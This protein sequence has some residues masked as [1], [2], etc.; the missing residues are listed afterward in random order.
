MAEEEEEGALAD[1]DLEFQEAGALEGP[2]EEVP[3]QDEPEDDMLEQVEPSDGGDD[4]GDEPPTGGAAAVP[5]AESQPARLAQLP[6]HARRQALEAAIAQAEAYNV[7][8]RRQYV[9]R[10]PQCAAA[11]GQTRATPAPVRFGDDGALAAT[12][13]SATPAAAEPAP[14]PPLEPP[15]AHVLAAAAARR[16]TAAAKAAAAKAAAAKAAAPPPSAASGSGALAGLGAMPPAVPRGPRAGVQPKA[17]PPARPQQP[18]MAPQPAPQPQPA[19][20]Q[21]AQPAAGIQPPQQGGPWA[22]FQGIGAFAAGNVGAYVAGGQ[23]GAG[24]PAPMPPAPAAAKAGP[25]VATPLLQ[26]LNDRK[27]AA[28]HEIL[29]AGN[30]QPSLANPYPPL[31]GYT[32]L[33]IAA[34][35]GPAEPG[36]LA[37]DLESLYRDLCRAALSDNRGAFF[38]MLRF[39]AEVNV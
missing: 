3:A 39:C 7:V 35:R 1:E 24:P 28:A 11:S 27:W 34:S 23:G 30:S 13:T 14:A 5:P 22:G 21:P 32:A 18:S 2:E 29:R 33:H 31:M 26:A 19:A 4:D 9:A 37:G 25:P 12:A 10:P 15:P 17:R 6:D 38:R 20:A 8:S 36:N 16:A